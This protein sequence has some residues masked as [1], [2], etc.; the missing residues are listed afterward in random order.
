M[1]RRDLLEIRAE[2]LKKWI[3]SCKSR[4]INGLVI[5]FP[6]AGVTREIRKM[7]EEKLLKLVTGR[8][9]E[10]S[11]LT[12]LYFDWLNDSK[13]FESLD[14]YF[15]AIK[16]GQNLV[17]VV[18]NPSVVESEQFKNCYGAK[19]LYDQY[20]FGVMSKE[21]TTEMIEGFEKKVFEKEKEKIWELSGG[22]AQIAKHLV[23]RNK[24]RK[25][26]E[27]VGDL[28]IK[29]MCQPMVSVIKRSSR[30]SLEK[31]GIVNRGKILSEVLATMVNIEENFVDIKVRLDLLVLEDGESF[32]E[33]LSRLERDILE[34]MLTN[35]GFI[36]KDLVAEIKWGKA[37][38]EKFSD[39]A[40]NKTMRRLDKRL[41]RYEVVTKWKTG[42]MLALRN[43]D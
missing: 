10:L 15:L 35:G 29:V 27:L 1:I 42:Y 40:I 43:D 23:L 13:V 32:G 4:Q 16:S 30:Q 24:S 38:Y 8:G 3:L 14:N 37:E 36:T 17:V 25:A 12:V 26:E 7:E 18:D 28:A 31:I 21:E 9:G 19:K 2:E 6:G 22:V 39:Q 41:H 34:R 33:R 20:W 11:E 5:T